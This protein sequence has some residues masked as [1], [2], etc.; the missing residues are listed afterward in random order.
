MPKNY[1]IMQIWAES[2]KSFF[3][4]PFFF[5]HNLLYFPILTI[6]CPISTRKTFYQC[7]QNLWFVRKNCHPNRKKSLCYSCYHNLCFHNA[8][9]RFWRIFNLAPSFQRF[10][11]FNKR[12][13][14]ACSPS[15]FIILLYRYISQSNHFICIF[16]LFTAN[17]SW[18]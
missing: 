12:T 13:I 14:P 2:G 4:T 10:P 6:I 9:I 8:F 7:L 18:I 15:V 1:C 17:P 5:L 3:H 16:R 11:C